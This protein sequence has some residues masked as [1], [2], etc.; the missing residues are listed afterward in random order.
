MNKPE[1]DTVSQWLT[2]PSLVKLAA[3]SIKQGNDYM[4]QASMLPSDLVDKVKERLEVYNG[5]AAII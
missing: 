4:L 5:K 1:R 2:I 3:R